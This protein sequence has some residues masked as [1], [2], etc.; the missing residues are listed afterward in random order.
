LL[1]VRRRMFVLAQIAG[2][3]ANLMFAPFS[4]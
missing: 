2:Q 1:R 3:L 4:D